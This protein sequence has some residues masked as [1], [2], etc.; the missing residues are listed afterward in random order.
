LGDRNARGQNGGATI[1]DVARESGFSPMTVSRVV[2]GEKNVKDSTRTAVLEAVNKLNYSPNLAARMLAGADQIRIGLIYSNPSAAYLSRYLVG[3][4]EQARRNHVQ[5]V[6]EDCADVPDA[7]NVIRELVASGMDGIV[8]S[9]PL[10]DNEEILALI[11]KEHISTVVIANWR[12]PGE[13]SVVR[14]DDIEAAQAMTR[15]II[16]LGHRRIGF[17]KGNPT[18][19]ASGQRLLGFKSALEE[20]GIPFDPDL[21]VQGQFTYRSGLE[22]ADQLLGLENPPTAIFASNDDMAAAAVTVAHRRQ[23]D[24]PGDVTI[25]GF[26]DTDFSQSIWPEL[27]TI[28]QPIAAMARAAVDL[29][30]EQIRNEKAG[31]PRTVSD[32]VLDYTF[33]R[34]D[35]DKAPKA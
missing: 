25:C 16:S 28:H 15:H 26:D 32:R 20:A 19:M 22:A 33:V 30:V 3:S 18:Q 11:E 8:M 10:C 27:T 9:P 35:S 21:V 24:V 14:I 12:P 2:N 31:N 4:L 7:I 17:V 5:L 23:L 13:F 34:R 6:I 1:A 29:L